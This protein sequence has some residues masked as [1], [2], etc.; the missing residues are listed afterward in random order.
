MSAFAESSSQPEVTP[1][2]AVSEATT[3]RPRKSILCVDDD[4][5]NLRMLERIL[6]IRPGWNFLSAL[7]GTPALE[8]ARKFTPDAI[9]LDL[10]LPDFGGKEVVQRLQDDPR[11]SQIPVVIVSGKILTESE[12]EQLIGAGV[13]AV[14]LKPYTVAEFFETLDGSLAGPSEPGR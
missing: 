2:T 5:S 11:T 6:Q 4:I 1:A 14:L 13:R 12:R 9:L 10:H 8:L 7:A 3:D